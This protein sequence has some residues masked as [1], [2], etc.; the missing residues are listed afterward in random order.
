MQ[1]ENFIAQICN[2]SLKLAWRDSE[3]WKRVKQV[4]FRSLEIFSVHVRSESC[5][6]F[7][8]D[9]VEY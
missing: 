1:A 8:M 5:K 7:Q 4:Y 9:A 6:S 2:T 3:G